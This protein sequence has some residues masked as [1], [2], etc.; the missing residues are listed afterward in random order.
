MKIGSQNFVQIIIQDITEKKIANEKLRESEKKLRLQN[1]E[2]MELDKLKTDFISIAAHELKTPLVSVGGYVDLILL[3]END[4]KSEIKDDLERVLNNVR[5][6]E[7]Y[8]NKL[9]DVM[10]I[11]ANKMILEKNVLN[12]SQ[13]VSEVIE[14]LH[15]QIISKKLTIET[16]I[17]DKIEIL[18]D[19]FRLSQ[20]ILNLLTNAIKFSEEE[21]KIEFHVNKQ[22]SELVVKI[23]DYGKGLTNEE[24]SKLFGKFVTIDHDSDTFSSLEKGS[25]LGLYISKGIIEA[26]GGKIGVES[27][28]LDQGSEFFFTLPI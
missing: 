17:D 19:Q 3:R 1:I 27:L 26:H 11:E 12:F 25:G 23:R 10:K 22:S 13:L 6:L 24:Q 14:E 28:G 18:G 8:I 16:D 5:R 7:E 9:L 4:L 21:S 2:L 15:F 20:V